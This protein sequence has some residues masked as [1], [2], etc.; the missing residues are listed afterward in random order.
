MLL[1]LAVLVV[2]AAAAWAAGYQAGR[3]AQR[4]RHRAA[5]LRTPMA[6]RWRDDLP[7]VQSPSPN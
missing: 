3:Q 1:E 7:T 6:G 4:R 2:V 5:R